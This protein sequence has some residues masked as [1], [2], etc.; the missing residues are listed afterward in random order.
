MPSRA[1]AG[2]TISFAAAALG[3]VVSISA[4]EN[5]DVIDVTRL[6]AARAEH[7]VGQSDL[8]CD[9][10]ITGWAAGALAVGDLGD[11]VITP[12]DGSGAITLVNMI[13]TSVNRN[14]P[15][16]GEL[17]SSVSFRAAYTAP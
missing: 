10:E 12:N 16:R 13:V 3:E 4:T 17:T 7:D 14:S 8:G 5:G 1:A 11:I 2:T 15:K 9:I 6:A